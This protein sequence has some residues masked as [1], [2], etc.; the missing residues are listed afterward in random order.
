MLFLY[1]GLFQ[2]LLDVTEVIVR[3]NIQAHR[4]S[5]RPLTVF[6]SSGENYV[7]FQVQTECYSTTSST[8]TI[9]TGVN[10]RWMY[11]LGKKNRTTWST[12][13]NVKDIH[14]S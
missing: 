3:P 14:N 5:N 7:F 13:V 12:L 6:S 2:D 8:T 11:R 9:R 10:K 4:E 1:T